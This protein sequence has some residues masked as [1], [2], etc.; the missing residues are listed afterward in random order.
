MTV[1]NKAYKY[2]AYPTKEQE[3][4]FAKTFGC[5]RYIYNQMLADKIAH[6]QQTKEMLQT[7]PAQYKD[8]APWLREVDSLALSNAQLNL[9]TAYKNFFS[10]P[11]TGFPQFKSKK[12]SKQSYTTN[13]Q[14]GSIRLD[15]TRIRLPKVGFVKLA[16]HRQI[17]ADQQIKSVTISLEPTGK[18]YI[19]VLVEYEA[20]M[21]EPQLDPNK[22]LGL[23][24]SSPHFYVDSEG[25]AADMPHFYR[26]AEAKLAR[27]QRKLSKMTR[28]SSNYRRQK[29]RVA[30]AYE[31]VRNCRNDYL[32]KE[33]RR[34]AD[35]Y[36]Y[37]CLED[38]NMQVMARG[39]NLAKAT[40][41]NGFGMFRNML[42]YKMQEQG[43]MVITI[44][45]WY[46]SS[47]TCAHCGF[48]NADLTLKDRAWVCPSC[49]CLVNRDHNAAINIK[50]EGLRMI[51]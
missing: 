29:V 36:D 40:L 38:L 33:S 26:N 15:G 8:D 6:Y 46:P 20:D 23:D 35:Q 19:S 2:R 22:A 12:R 24:Y 42:T 51:V 32:H 27:E 50:T 11:K 34:L 7:T 47:K 41:D 3:I 45:K 9:Q 4:L 5:V 21:P 13:N 25:N 1:Q 37:I 43:K 14:K 49:G 30:R 31:H 17:P 10:N 39:L 16:L 48:I 18:Y 28:G 44:N